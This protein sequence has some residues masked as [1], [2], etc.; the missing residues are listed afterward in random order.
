MPSLKKSATFVLPAGW[1]QVH[2]TIE[3]VEGKQYVQY[4]LLKALVRGANFDQV[5]YERYTPEI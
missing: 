2:R 3:V 1:F 5:T 4:R